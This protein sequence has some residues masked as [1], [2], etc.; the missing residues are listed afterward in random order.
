MVAVHCA[1]KRCADGDQ[2]QRVAFGEHAQNDGQDQGG[3]APG[4]AH[5]ESDEAGNHEDDGRQERK[6]KA[7]SGKE[8]GN[9]FARTQHVAACAA[10]APCQNK[11][12]DSAHHRANAFGSAFS[13]ANQGGELTG[14]EHACSNH[15]CHGGTDA[16]S[17]DGVF[18]NGGCEVYALKE[19]ANIQHA[20]DGEHD[21]HYDG[22]N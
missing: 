13:E 1:S 16:Q 17:A 2:E 3:G 12:H 7:H 20:R 22:D 9:E 8:V 15:Q 5:G 6:L 18:T 11:D 10:Q 19:A 4:G 14:Q 21:K